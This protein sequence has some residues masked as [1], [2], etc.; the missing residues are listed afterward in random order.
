MSIGKPIGKHCKSF[1]NTNHYWGKIENGLLEGVAPL[2]THMVL[3][4]H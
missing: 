3:H 1:G 4:N 2:E